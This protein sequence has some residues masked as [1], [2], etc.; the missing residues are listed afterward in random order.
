MASTEF[1]SRHPCPQACSSGDASRSRLPGVAFFLPLRRA[2]ASVQ[3]APPFW[4]LLTASWPMGS[5]QCI[6]GTFRGQKAVSRRGR[7]SCSRACEHRWSFR[8]SIR[9]FVCRRNAYQIPQSPELL[10]LAQQGTQLEPPHQQPRVDRCLSPSSLSRTPLLPCATA[11]AL[12]ATRINSQ[13][14]NTG[15][16]SL[17]T[18]PPLPGYCPSVPDSP[19]PLRISTPAHSRPLLRLLPCITGTTFHFPQIQIPRTPLKLSHDQPGACRS[20]RQTSLAPTIVTS[21]PLLYTDDKTL[22]SLPR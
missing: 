5:L 3:P 20:R 14:L 12:P 6:P 18:N 11:A 15:P 2:L 9:S 1:R 19:H 8:R 16:C 4:P 21:G 13:H 17:P 10:C 22:S 7:S